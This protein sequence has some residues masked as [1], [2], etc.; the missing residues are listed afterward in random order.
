MSDMT[1]KE[2]ATKILKDKPFRIEVIN[3]CY[4]VEPDKEDKD[5]FYK[6]LY[7]GVEKMGYEFGE[8]VFKE[9]LKAQFDKLNGF[10][11]IAFLG[12]LLNNANKA[13]KAAG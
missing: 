4:D 7:I 12:S 13:K 10:K 1:V 9:E 2:V 6:W 5:A 11:K 8:E 3:N